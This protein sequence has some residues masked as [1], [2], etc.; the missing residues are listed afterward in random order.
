MQRRK[1]PDLDQAVH[2]E[3]TWN[4]TSALIH[5]HRRCSGPLMLYSYQRRDSGA[6][7]E[8]QEMIDHWFIASSGEKSVCPCRLRLLAQHIGITRLDLAA[9]WPRGIFSHARSV[10]VIH[11]PNQP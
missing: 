4:C 9:R 7:R 6:L 10:V 1:E 2:R 5:P 3:L 8:L 11:D